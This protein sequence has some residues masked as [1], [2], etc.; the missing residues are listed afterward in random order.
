MGANE[1]AGT[2]YCT[3]LTTFMV[4]RKDA[5]LFQMRGGLTRREWV[6]SQRGNDAIVMELNWQQMRKKCAVV[7]P[8]TSLGY[9]FRK[10]VNQ[11]VSNQSQ[12]LWCY[13]TE[14]TTNE[15]KKRVVENF[16]LRSG[17]KHLLSN[18][19][20]SLLFSFRKIVNQIVSNQSQ[21]LWSLGKTN[22]KNQ[23]YVMQKSN[24][25]QS[26]TSLWFSF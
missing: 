14:L 4:A 1:A 26:I 12:S 13:G 6:R 10:I 16:E 2:G 9:F 22:D 25:V 5:R 17:E 18:Q 24:S 19:S 20:Q 15:G 3:H 11:I 23:N 8:I 7:Q 21:S